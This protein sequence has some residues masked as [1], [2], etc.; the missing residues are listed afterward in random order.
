MI[1]HE[2]ILEFQKDIANLLSKKVTLIESRD[3]SEKRMIIAENE[4]QDGLKGRAIIQDTAL[5]VQQNLEL[6]I[7]ETVSMALR[8]VDSSESP[9][10][11]L[12]FETK[13][14]QTEC[15]PVFIEHGKEQHPE[16]SSGFGFIN[17]ATF[18]L[19]IAIWSITKNS[20]VL[21]CDEPF[22]DL[23]PNYHEKASEMVV[24][25]CES[26][27]LQIILISHSTTINTKAN[28]NLR[29]EKNKKIS[30]VTVL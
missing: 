10:F 6:Y 27:N 1:T 3:K 23:S 9:E 16:G 30:S 8:A 18:A 11:K 19:R 2:A 24:R 4:Y 28:L 25:L 14:N 5:K 21:I 12:K 7:S 17:I 20:P 26:E 22:R 29:V 15:N 13:R